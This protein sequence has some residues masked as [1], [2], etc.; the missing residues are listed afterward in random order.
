MSNVP[1]DFNPNPEH[2]APAPGGPT[3]CIGCHEVRPW[4][5]WSGKLRVAESCYAKAKSGKGG[6]VAL[7]HEV[8]LSM[9]AEVK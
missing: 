3:E 5:V 1:S 2:L 7:P 6:Q 9:I 8:F 4:H